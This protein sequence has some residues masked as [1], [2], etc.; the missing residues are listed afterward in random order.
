MAGLTGAANGIIGFLVM[1]NLGR[2][3]SAK[4]V[5][6]NLHGF[7]L[8]FPG[9]GVLQ[10]GAAA[11]LVRRSTIGRIGALVLASVSILMWMLWLGAYPLAAVEAIVFD[12]LVIY[13]L[14]VTSE[15]LKATE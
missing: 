1:F 5:A 15:S 11:L 3:S 10:I 6:L 8:I 14:P 2:F 9:F 4:L 13:G 12:V 7:G